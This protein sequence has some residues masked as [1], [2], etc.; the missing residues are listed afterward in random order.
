MA[1]HGGGRVALQSTLSA[2]GITI[3]ETGNLLGLSYQVGFGFSTPLPATNALNGDASQGT[4]DHVGTNLRLTMPIKFDI[5]PTTLPAPLNTLL[6]ADFTMTGQL[7][8]QAP[9]QVVPEP[10]SI[11]L[12]IVGFAGLAG[13]ARRR[14]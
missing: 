4:V 10:S 8:G 11:A 5:T 14:R 1:R 9:F 2:Q 7:I 13:V 12:A 6:T 3:T